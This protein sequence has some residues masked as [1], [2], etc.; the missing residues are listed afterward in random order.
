MTSDETEA[1]HAVDTII[2]GHVM[3]DDKIFVA[4]NYA[5]HDDR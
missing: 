4:I 3:L 5:Q 1:Q 2:T